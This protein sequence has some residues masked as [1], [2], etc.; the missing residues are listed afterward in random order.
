[1]TAERRK[2]EDDAAVDPIIDPK[3]KE[4]NKEVPTPGASSPA[5]VS[6]TEQRRENETDANRET[7]GRRKRAE[8]GL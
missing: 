4:R 3:L 5:P 8:E 1:M 7:D 6:Q 2:P